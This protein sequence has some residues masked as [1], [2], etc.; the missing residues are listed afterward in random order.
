ML[1]F[2]ASDSPNLGLTIELYTYRS[3]Q[4]DSLAARNE[5]ARTRDLEGVLLI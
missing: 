1:D 3:L 2:G 5:L 4:V